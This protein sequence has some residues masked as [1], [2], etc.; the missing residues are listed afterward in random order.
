MTPPLPSP[1]ITGLQ[2]EKIDLAPERLEQI[3]QNRTAGPVAA[4]GHD[5]EFL[6]SDSVRIH[7]IESQDALNVLPDG[8]GIGR[9]LADF[10]PFGK[11]IRLFLQPLQDAVALLGRQKKPVR[12]QQFERIPFPW[13]MTRGDD[14]PSGVLGFF[15]HQLGRGRR[16]DANVDDIAPHGHE[17]AADGIL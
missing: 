9:H 3:R 4:I 10:I 17:P 16:C 8:R 1:A 5:L 2:M 12:R 6:F 7:E 15:G 11:P 13:I 14:D